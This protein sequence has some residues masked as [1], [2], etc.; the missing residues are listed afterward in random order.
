MLKNLQEYILFRKSTIGEHCT[1]E[2]TWILGLKFLYFLV[3]LY[4]I[5]KKFVELFYDQEIIYVPKVVM[6]HGRSFVIVR[7]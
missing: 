4:M 5:L 1:N 2:H 3:E 7:V 6:W